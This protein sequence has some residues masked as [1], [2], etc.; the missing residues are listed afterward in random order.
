[1]S[2]APQLYITYGARRKPGGI[3]VIKKLRLTQHLTGT[4]QNSRDDNFRRS[5]GFLV[6]G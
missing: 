3:T 2:H 6:I 4:G 5:Q 1:M